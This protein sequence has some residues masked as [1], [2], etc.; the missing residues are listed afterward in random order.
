[1]PGKRS[2]GGAP[3]SVLGF[4]QVA[5]GATAPRMAAA[6]Q[7]LPLRGG[8]CSLRHK[9]KNEAGALTLCKNTLFLIRFSVF[10]L[11][12]S[13]FVTDGHPSLS[14]LCIGTRY[15]V[16]ALLVTAEC[17]RRCCLG[18]LSA[19]WLRAALT[20]VRHAE[21]ERELPLSLPALFSDPTD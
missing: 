8:S 3:A 7:P 21:R 20:L 1:M 18:L 12:V 16:C 11:T 4:G 14:V 17:P 9:Y 19:P 15:C 6:H 13:C 2:T 5:E 10:A